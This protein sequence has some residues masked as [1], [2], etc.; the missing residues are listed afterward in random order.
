MTSLSFY[1]VAYELVSDVYIAVVQHI[2]DNPFYSDAT[3]QKAKQYVFLYPLI[4][5]GF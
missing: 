4:V 1:Q 5:L 3:L 2:D